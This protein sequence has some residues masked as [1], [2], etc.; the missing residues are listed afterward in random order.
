[1]ETAKVSVNPAKSSK[2]SVQ[3]EKTASA[4]ALRW[5]RPLEDGGGQPVVE[6]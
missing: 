2:K 4:K 5:E 1:M 3:A 6:A